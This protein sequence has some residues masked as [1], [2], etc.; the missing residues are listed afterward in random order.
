MFVPDT[1]AL[2]LG[3]LL[4]D[5]SIDVNGKSRNGD[6]RMVLNTVLRIIFEFL[7]QEQDAKIF[8]EGSSPARTRLYQIAIASQLDALRD[9]FNIAGMLDGEFQD[10]QIGRSYSAFVISL[11]KY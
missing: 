10:F 8:V 1:Y 2:L 4:G 5:G 3:D 9:Q 6:T 11:K 7:S